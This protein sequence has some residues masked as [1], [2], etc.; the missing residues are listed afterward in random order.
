MRED[1]RVF[2]LKIQPQYQERLLK[3]EDAE[4]VVSSFYR[5][6]AS[7]PRSASTSADQSE[8]RHSARDC[9]RRRCSC[10]GTW[11]LQEAGI[12][13]DIEL[14]DSSPGFHPSARAE[15]VECGGRW[16]ERQPVQRH[17][18]GIT[19]QERLR[20]YIEPDQSLHHVAA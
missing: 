7:R 20:L 2:L 8:S 12:D 18:A 4:P 14:I 13:V 5:P 6:F 16:R 15:L 1:A 17:S 9:D 19:Y 3:V 11:I 10:Q